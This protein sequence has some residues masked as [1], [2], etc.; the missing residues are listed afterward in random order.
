MESFL[1]ELNLEGESYPVLKC[2]YQFTQSTDATG[3]PNARAR[4]GLIEL[5]FA[6][7]EDDQLA[8]WAINPQKKMNGK[9]CFARLQIGGVK[10]DNGW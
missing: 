1:T 3:Q 10:H 8:N 6:D 4:S 5:Y 7:V 2:H 9:I